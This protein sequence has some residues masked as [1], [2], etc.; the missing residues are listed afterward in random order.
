[1]ARRSG[2]IEERAE[3]K[4]L[5][6]VYLGEDAET[7]KRK[8]HSE[9]VYGKKK[10]A[11]AVLNKLLNNQDQGLAVA[12]TRITLKAYIDDW[13]E[14]AARPR[15][16]ART[17]EAYEDMMVRYVYLELGSKRLAKL[18]PLDIQ[19]L[20]GKLYRAKEDKGL[21][22][23]AR[24][25]RY[26]HTVLSNALTQAVKWQILPQNVAQYVDLPRQTRQEMTALSEAEV[27]QFMK[28]AKRSSHH[29]LFALLIGTGLRPS[30]AFGLQWSDI[31]FAGS[32]LSVQRT[33]STS[34]QGW[35]F[36]PPKTA[37]GRRNVTL[38]A[39]LVQLLLDHRAEQSENPYNLVF[40]N[41]AGNPLNLRNV[42]QRHFKA[43]LK[44][45][46]LSEAVRLYDLRHT[47]ATLL[48]GKGVHP[49]IV[50]ERLGHATITLTLDTYSHVLP[51]MQSDS[52]QKLDALLFK[53]EGERVQ[54]YN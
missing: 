33:V 49:K 43:L 2:R 42:T 23:S 26:C 8:Y 30:E 16:R 13:L 38:P 11:Q 37:K 31:D 54:A 9:I 25:V 48:L 12:P 35:K 15:L 52:A 32:T 50:S 53:L 44:E 27:D 21:G 41:V 4:F 45:A 51:N 7:R 19:G 36:Q 6:R 1:M 22:L 20:Y 3:G 47:H 40:V 34:K 18:T 46:G 39:T 14:R 5:V 28:A 29:I 17:F 24:T 10:D